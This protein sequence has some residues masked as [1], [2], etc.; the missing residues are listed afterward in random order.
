MR[1]WLIIS[2]GTF[3]CDEFLLSGCFQES[4]SFAFES[5][6]VKFMWVSLLLFARSLLRFLG[7]YAHVFHQVWGGFALYFFK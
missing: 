4:L 1:N 7:V 6:I 5:L 2:L 3:G